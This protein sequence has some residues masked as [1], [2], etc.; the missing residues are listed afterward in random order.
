[1]S[2]FAPDEKVGPFMIRA[3][4]T[5]EGFSSVVN[6][7]DK[8]VEKFDGFASEA[9]ALDAARA[10]AVEQAALRKPPPRVGVRARKITEPQRPLTELREKFLRHF[11][12][13]FADPAYLEKE[14]GYKD[15]ARRDLLSAVSL[16]D[17]QYATTEQCLAARSALT[18]MLFPQEQIRLRE[19]LKSPSG[20]GFLRSAAQVARGDLKAGFAGID[21]AVRPFGT[22][23]WTIATYVPSLWSP[24]AHMLMR[25]T[26]TQRVA[27]WLGHAFIAS[28]TPRLEPAVYESMLDLAAMLQ[29]ELADLEPRDLIDI[30]SFIWVVTDYE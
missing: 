6:E 18:N 29:R 14:R 7:G 28:Y 4:P 9:L 13:G 3:R 1:M 2:K 19:V 17:A 27:N 16:E 25:I 26:A 11:P 30:Q 5:K 12:Q 8:R 23:S 15:K 10:Y 20:P 21:A 24:D 22:P